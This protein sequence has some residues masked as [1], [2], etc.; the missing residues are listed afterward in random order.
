M[1][2]PQHV[3]FRHTDFLPLPLDASDITVAYEGPS[4]TGMNAPALCFYDGAKTYLTG[5]SY[6]GARTKTFTVPENARYFRT[7]YRS[8]M[9]SVN[10]VAGTA[11]AT[12]D[13]PY[14][15]KLPIISNDIITDIYI[16]DTQLAKDEY[17]DSKSN[18]IYKYKEVHSDTVTINGIEWDILGY[19]HD[20]VYREDGT[21]AQHTVT[22]QTHDCIDNL[23]FD[24]R[25]AL[26]ALPDGLAAGSYTFTI[27]AHS[28]VSTD[29]NKS[30]T[31][32]LTQAIPKGGQLVV[33]QAY[34]ASFTT[35]NIS[36]YASSSAT[37]PIETVKMN[38]GDTGT[39]LGDV[40]NAIVDN[41]NS[42]Q[43]ALGGSNRWGTSALRQFL[44]SDKAAG[45]FWKAQT[46]FDRP[47]SWA[48]TTAGFLYDMDSDFVSVIGRVSKRTALNT[49]SDGGGYEDSVEK[50]FLPS[51]SEV[52]AGKENNI[53]EGDPY[54][55]FKDFSDFS[56]PSTGKDTNRIKYKN[57]SAEYWW[58]RSPITSYAGSVRI[59][60][61]PGELNSS[62]VTSSRGV[63]PACC[64]ILDDISQS[65]WLQEHFLKAIDPP[66]QLP[67][68]PT[69]AGETTI[70][71]GAAA[72]PYTTGLDG[73]F[74]YGDIDGLTWK[75]SVSGENDITFDT[76]VTDTGAEYVLPAGAS[77]QYTR[78]R[79]NTAQHSHGTV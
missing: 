70:D 61:P 67:Q 12:S 35:G 55:Y 68:I 11:P 66:S 65:A 57:G 62:Y 43:R 29:V 64:I 50:V 27:K 32:T 54:D 72:L 78:N 38:E 19:D 22:I 40:T 28:W 30:L 24:A 73:I 69:F 10:V 1:I 59:I 77:G 46:A 13:T 6:E 9:T 21:L 48:A 3:N 20:A 44:N 23:Q 45:T 25:E 7:S 15:F 2:S 26:F 75:N 74:E 17:V 63:T 36:S 56:A 33:S 71:Y 51:R 37:E 4:G 34:N 58:L 52:Y 8:T 39:S 31:F 60:N 42:C 5:E 49:V 16:G 53:D 18:K 76:V 14:G 41:T 47:P 79:A